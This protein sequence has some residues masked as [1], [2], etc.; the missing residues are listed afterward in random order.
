MPQKTQQRSNEQ[1]LS[2]MDADEAIQGVLAKIKPEVPKALPKHVGISPEQFLR[3]ACTEMRTNPAL[4]VADKMSLFGSI[5]EAAQMGLVIGGALQRC[6]LV[7][8]NNVVSLMIGFQGFTELAYRSGKVLSLK[9]EVVCDG[10]IYHYVET[11]KG[12]EF[13][14]AP[15]PKDKERGKMYATWARGMMQNNI[16]QVVELRRADV[17][18][19]K[20]CAKGTDYSTSPWKKHEPE[21]WKKTAVR[22]LS[23]LLPMLTEDA[24][25]KKAL[26]VDNRAHDFNLLDAA[27]TLPRPAGGLEGTKAL[28]M[29]RQ[30]DLT[31]VDDLDAPANEEVAA[32][33]E[34][35]QPP[36]DD[37]PAFGFNCTVC[38]TVFVEAGAKEDGTQLAKCP[39][40]QCKQHDMVIE[41]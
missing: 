8:Y 33:P 3:I 12:P 13:S 6:W 23:K 24:Y 11:H 35:I 25:F 31:V 22:N 27:P 18:R 10:D 39:N 14:W 37:A 34:V 5:L 41:V 19:A 2:P 38:S 40:E 7:P 29:G 36:A 28:I 26:E 32:E 17:M 4:L 30:P 9:A 1:A 20:A 21:M 15:P 16:C